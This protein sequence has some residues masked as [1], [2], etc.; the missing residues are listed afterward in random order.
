MPRF[1][2]LL[3]LLT[4]CAV[5][6]EDDEVRYRPKTAAPAKTAQSRSY[7]AAAYT[8]AKTAHA[9]EAAAEKRAEPAHAGFWHFFRPK[10]AAQPAKLADASPA[11]S[12]PFVQRPP[13][14]VPTMTP[15][16]KAI[17]MDEHKPYVEGESK[18]VSAGYKPADKPREKNPLLAPRQGIKEP[19]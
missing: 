15:D 13:I 8:P 16:R 11:A 3:L 5:R 4:C 19:Q 17:N 2:T 14:T 9:A 1:V 10:P 6:A 12:E 18:L 7:Q